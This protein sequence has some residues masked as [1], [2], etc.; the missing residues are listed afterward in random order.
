MGKRAEPPSMNPESLQ[1]PYAMPEGADE[2]AY[3]AR[4]A[5]VERLFREHNDALVRF[6]RARLR[7][8]QEALEVANS[9]DCDLVKLAVI[10]QKD[11]RLTTFILR[12]PA[13]SPLM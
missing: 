5:L 2:A 13:R 4:I 9:A 11:L 6:L 1:P 3:R 10:I 8:R 7:S 12:P